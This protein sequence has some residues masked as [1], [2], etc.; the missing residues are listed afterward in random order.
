MGPSEN[1]LRA[2]DTGRSW[3][4]EDG[5]MGACGGQLG[6]CG[7]LLVAEHWTQKVTAGSSHTTSSDDGQWFP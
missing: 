1:D 6:K 3:V 5:T 2:P 7:E 4:T